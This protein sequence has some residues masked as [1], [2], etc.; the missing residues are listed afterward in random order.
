V[1]KS[2]EYSPTQLKRYALWGATI[3]HR[4]RVLS[5]GRMRSDK[6]RIRAV[7][8]DMLDARWN[9]VLGRLNIWG[10]I[11]E[12]EYRA[13]E[14]WSSL[15]ARYRAIA[16]GPRTVRSGELE[17]RGVTEL[18]DPDSAVGQEQAERDRRIIAASVAAY[19]CLVASGLVPLRVVLGVCEDS[20]VSFRDC[21]LPVL[22]IGLRALAQHWHLT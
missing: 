12:V 6:E 7:M 1:P 16:H 14:L 20:D 17:R 18:V 21:D 10:R 22:Q 13:V 11:T 2:H 4:Y 3:E 9:S 15:V 8:K 19:E 5:Q